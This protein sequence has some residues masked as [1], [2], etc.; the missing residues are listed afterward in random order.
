[1]TTRMAGEIAVRTSANRLGLCMRHARR[2]AVCVA[3]LLLAIA[4]RAGAQIDSAWHF[5]TSPY[6]WAS[7]LNGNVGV[8]P[9]STR[10]DLSFHDILKALK[11][12]FMDASEVRWKRYLV[13]LDGFYVS[14]GSAKSIAIRG[15][16]GSISLDQKET[17]VQ[18]SLGYAFGSKALG[19]D[20]L[21]GFRYWDLSSDLNVDRPQ[22]SNEHSGSRQWVDAALGARLHWMPLARWRVTVG[23]DAGGGGAKSTWQAYGFV[24]GDIK[25]WFSVGAGYRGLSVDYDH[26]GFLFDTSTQGVMITTTFRF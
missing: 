3:S 6:F 15:D 10:V 16:T 4:A 2:L 20:V 25:S 21:G 17:M 19:V 11:F 13:D 1:M 24:G 12:G 7:G 23:G 9:L 14:L 18:P 22:A 5:S 26:N 8:G